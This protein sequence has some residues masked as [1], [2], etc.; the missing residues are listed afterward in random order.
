MNRNGATILKP[1]GTTQ[2]GAP[3][4]LTFEKRPFPPY[5]RG[6]LRFPKRCFRA[7]LS[8]ISGK[9]RWGQSWGP[10]SSLSTS[11]KH[12]KE[13]KPFPST[14]PRSK[15]ANWLIPG[16]VDL[17]ENRAWIPQKVYVW[18]FCDGFSHSGVISSPRRIRYLFPPWR[19]SWAFRER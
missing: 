3:S 17:V 1:M 2:L 5:C 14:L 12:I 19:Q 10:I 7:K 11:G 13:R 15:F 8:G 18:R 9:G 4:I 16:V 6:G